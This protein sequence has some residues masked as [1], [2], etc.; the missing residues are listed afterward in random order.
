M[1]HGTIHAE[2]D[3]LL[4]LPYQARAKKISLGVFTTN[5]QGT[6]LLM[7]KCCKQCETSIKILCRKKKY[8]LKR[9][10]YIDE[11]GQVQIL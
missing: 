2:V 3:A 6:S 9:I 5:R 11:K 8:I 1:Q 10:Y 4:R 7:S